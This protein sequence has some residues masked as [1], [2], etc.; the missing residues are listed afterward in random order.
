ML[1]DKKNA[2]L[3]RDSNG[4]LLPVNVKLETLDD[5]VEVILKPMSKGELAE[6][7]NNSKLNNNIDGDDIKIISKFCVK[8]VFTDDE[9][10]FLKP[11]ISQAIIIALLSVSTGLNQKNLANKLK[12]KINKIS[13]A[14]D[15]MNQKKN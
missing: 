4:E 14:E 6:I 11:I 5:D 9:V 1:L 2:L 13:E 8:P 3:E 12:D 10:K 7:S 15:L